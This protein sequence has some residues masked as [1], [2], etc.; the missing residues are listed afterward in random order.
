MPRD[1]IKEMKICFLT[2]T[3]NIDSGWGRYSW[4]VIS[5]INK[6]K[7]VQISV[8]TENFS[9]NFLEKPILKNSLRNLFFIFPNAMRARK[10]IKQCDIIHCLDAYPYGIIA[11]LANIGLNKKLIINVVGSYSVAP[12]E[13]VNKITL[14]RW[15]YRKIKKELLYWAYKK[16]D[17]V[18]CISYFTEKEILKRIDL[19]NTEVIHLGIDF[20]KFQISNFVNKKN[21]ED[22]VILSVGELKKRKGYHISIPAMVDVKKKY[23]NFKYYIVGHQRNKSFF[24]ELKQ[25]VKKH[26]L[27]NN[28]IFLQGISDEELIDLY[29][30]S[31]LFLLT[32]V[33]IGSHFEGF[34]LVFLEAGACGK[35]VIGTSGCGIED[36]I[37]DNFN[38]LL[39]SQND[40]KKTSHVVLKILDNPDLAKRLGIN[41]KKKAQ[42]MSWQNTVK[43][44]IKIYKFI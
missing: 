23:P 39:V 30:K 2:N 42:N 19:K 43:K 9:N 31:D 15:I 35:P 5:R 20:D 8:L 7:N 36:A 6:E 38:G 21:R 27:D 12:L 34:G 18:P 28:V 33:N 14:I 26:Q 32:S 24:D 40:I 3:L 1:I 25:L 11:T 41:G 16:A 17:S 44:Y 22:K 10:Y 4:E 29:Y 13:Q 37:E